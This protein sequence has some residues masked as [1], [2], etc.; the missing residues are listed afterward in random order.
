MAKLSND[1]FRTSFQRVSDRDGDGGERASRT[2]AALCDRVAHNNALCPAGQRGLRACYQPV[3]CSRDWGLC[4]PVRGGSAELNPADATSPSFT[5][6]FVKLPAGAAA[7][8]LPSSPRGRRTKPARM[9]ERPPRRRLVVFFFSLSLFLHHDRKKWL[10]GGRKKKRHGFVVF[11][12]GRKR[13]DQTVGKANT[14]RVL[15]APISLLDL[16]N[17]LKRRL[18]RSDRRSR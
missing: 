3:A 8:T 7:R 2:S 1:A 16:F 9:E 15:K 12:V 18:V 13:K 14:P 10:R 17:I 5:P 6:S 4:V 11:G